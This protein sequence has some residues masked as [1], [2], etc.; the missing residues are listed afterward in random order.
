MPAGSVKGVTAEQME[1]MGCQTILGN[2]YHLENRQAA[3][4]AL[5]RGVVAAA[6]PQLVMCVYG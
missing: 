5:A 6:A 2:T 4:G 1:A 3:G